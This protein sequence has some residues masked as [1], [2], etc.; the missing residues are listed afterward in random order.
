MA[1]STEPL[2][3]SQ[4]FSGENTARISRISKSQ[5]L[6]HLEKGAFDPREAWFLRDDD[7]E[8]YVV[9]PQNI[10]KKIISIIR[11]AH[12]EKLLLELS[13]DISQQTPV[14][15][16]DV[17][18]V[19]LNKLESKRLPDG[20]LPKINTKSLIKAIKKQYPNLFLN[21]PEQFL[22]KGIR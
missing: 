1:S 9:M 13:R 7:G 10:L 16:D 22:F 15:F 8:E 17:M 11:N 2:N 19:A 14:D 12:E 3:P 20:S 5:I 21:I 6:L 4:I 18:A